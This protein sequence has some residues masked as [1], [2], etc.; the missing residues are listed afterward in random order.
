MAIACAIAALVIM[1]C[2]AAVQAQGNLAATHMS[3]LGRW[4]QMADLNRQAFE[5]SMA[6]TKRHGYKL[7]D[8]NNHDYGHLLTYEQYGYLQL[9]QPANTLSGVARTP[10]GHRVFRRFA[11]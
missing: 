9:G 4:Q 10:A 11:P 2:A 5:L 7:Q 8:L 3:Q 6:W 1:C